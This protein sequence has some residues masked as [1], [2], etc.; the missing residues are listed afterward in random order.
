MKRIF[1]SSNI[2]KLD[3]VGPVDNRPSTDQLRNFVQKK[4]ENENDM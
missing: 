3:V 1:S 2:T 4:N